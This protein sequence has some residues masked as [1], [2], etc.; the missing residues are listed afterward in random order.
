MDAVGFV[1]FLT[2][3]EPLYPSVVDQGTHLLGEH[4]V[5]E[6]SEIFS[7]ALPTDGIFLGEIGCSSGL[8]IIFG[9][10]DFTESS[11]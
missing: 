11:S 9:Y 5:A 10:H 1:F 2:H 6:V 4:G 8:V 3:R 7:V